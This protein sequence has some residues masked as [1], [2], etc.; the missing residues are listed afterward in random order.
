[1]QNCNFFRKSHC[2]YYRFMLNL[3]PRSKASWIS[4]I[5]ARIARESLEQR[6]IFFGI[7]MQDDCPICKSEFGYDKEDNEL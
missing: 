6:K 4:F 7:L 2:I 5:P 1:M 3:N